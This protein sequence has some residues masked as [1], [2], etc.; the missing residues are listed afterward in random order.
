MK[1]YEFQHITNEITRNIQGTSKN[2]KEYFPIVISLSFIFYKKKEGY[3]NVFPSFRPHN[4]PL[5]GRM[6]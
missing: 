2:L 3:Q 1:T 4:L 5:A 6:Y